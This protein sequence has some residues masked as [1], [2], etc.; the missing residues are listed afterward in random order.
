VGMTIDRKRDRPLYEHIASLP[1][2]VRFATHPLDGD[3][4]PLFSARA[5]MGG[6]ETLQPWFV[7]AWQRQKQRCEDTLTALY[8]TDRSTVLDYAKKHGVT[9]FLINTHRYGKGFRKHAGSFEPF[10]TFARD[11]LKGVK[12]NE[13]V[14]AQLP[15]S[16]IE[17]RYQ[18]WRVVSVQA[19]EQAWSEA[20][21][22]P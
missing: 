2:S 12:R 6:F 16:A 9:H 15:A 18:R 5:T 22:R 19:L 17:F 21:E 20:S 11:L 4:I 1:T 3:G 10:T 13:L 7:D 8:A 14:F